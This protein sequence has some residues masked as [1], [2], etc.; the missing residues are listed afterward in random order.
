[1]VL[2]FPTMLTHFLWDSRPGRNLEHIAEHGMTADL[3]E[4]VFAQATRHGPDKDDA[5]VTL[6]EGRVRGQ[7]YRILYTVLEDGTIMPLTILP[8]TGFPIERRGLR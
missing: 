7:L 8:I 2:P 5:T 6:A 3:W 1:M 4:A